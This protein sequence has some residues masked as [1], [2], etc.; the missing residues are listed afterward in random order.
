MTFNTKLL[1]GALALVLVAGMTSPAFADPTGDVVTIFVTGVPTD[2][3]EVVET[4]ANGPEAVFT[5]LNDNIP[6]IVDIGDGFILIEYPAGIDNPDPTNYEIIIQ[7][8]DWLDESGNEVP[9][10][11]DSLFCQASGL[12]IITTDVNAFPTNSLQG[13]SIEILVDP[14]AIQSTIEPVDIEC[15]YTVVHP[16]PQPPTTSV[17]GQLLPL[18]STALLI[19]GLTSMSVFM[20]PAVAGLAGAAVYLVKFRARD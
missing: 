9:G 15:V 10:E 1:A 18:D 6:F 5:T 3:D 7:D 4:V 13:S 14:F 16:E 2:P 19:G 11:I 20:I 17:A 8:I 12:E